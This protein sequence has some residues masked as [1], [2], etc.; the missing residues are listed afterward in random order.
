M[1]T[2]PSFGIVTVA[3]GHKRYM[4]QAEAL[5]FSIKLHMPGIRVAL[6]SDTTSP[7]HIFDD[8][9][10]INSSYGLGVIQKIWIDQYSPY[11]H[12][13]FI[14]ADCLVTRPFHKE[15]EEIKQ[16]DFTP[17]VGR[18]L[19][20]ED[21]EIFMEDL[22]ETLRMIGATEFPKY[23]G[24]VYFFKKGDLAKKIF[25]E[26]RNIAKEAKKLGLKNFDRG[27]VNDETVF[28]LALAKLHIRSLYNDNGRMM[29]TP[30]GL[31]GPLT[32]DVL[33]G[34]CSFV[35]EGVPVAPAVCH[36]AG[37]Y[38]RSWPYFYNCF[39]ARHPHSNGITRFLARQFFRIKRKGINS[40]NRLKD[41]SYNRLARFQRPKSRVMCSE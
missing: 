16:F 41:G 21:K 37:G 40:M 13:M 34:G 17:I 33:G 11:D 12:T 32:I 14:D 22:G 20:L 24:G 36:F 6:I 5:A 27:G 7:H 1:K 3:F 15:L 28:G 9:G 35:K 39:L 10:R 30:I 8:H 38:I 26:A 23:N 18:F 25:E 31:T 4:R 29:R 2:A 19:G